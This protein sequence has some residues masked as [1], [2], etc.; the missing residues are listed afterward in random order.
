MYVQCKYSSALKCD[1][2]TVVY[3][4]QCKKFVVAR[5]KEISS[6][7]V[8]FQYSNKV[9]IDGRVM[10]SRD[11]NKAKSVA[12][13]YAIKLNTK[14]KRLSLSQV[15]SLALSNEFPDER[16]IYIEHSTKLQGDN[17]KLKGVLNS[18]VETITL[19]GGLV[20]IYVAP[21]IQFNLEYNK[22]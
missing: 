22:I 16:V 17:E 18:F 12:L 21:T 10:W 4:K 6:E 9:K 14:I 2:C 15:I 5:A 7:L 1:E 3:H 20:S 19:N 13:K 11:V 8:P